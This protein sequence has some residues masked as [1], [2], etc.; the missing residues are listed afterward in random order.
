MKSE[1][2]LH[3]HLQSSRVHEGEC[4]SSSSR[5]LQRDSWA[6]SLTSSSLF[7]RP[8]VQTRLD[9]PDGQPADPNST[10]AAWCWTTEAVEGQCWRMQ[11]LGRLTVLATQLAR[12]G[13]GFH[14]TSAGTHVVR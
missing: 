12:E 5:V 4:P 7:L 10:P 11:P 6:T 3:R 1:S 8:G 13:C 14:C 9:P 2:Q